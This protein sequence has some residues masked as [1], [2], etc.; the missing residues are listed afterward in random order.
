MSHQGHFLGYPAMQQAPPSSTGA[1]PSFHHPSFVPGGLPPSAY[2][3]F[4]MGP[5]DPQARRMSIDQMVNPEQKP[6][7]PAHPPNTA[8]MESLLALAGLERQQLA[9]K[10]SE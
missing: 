4:P 8:G 1:A 3:I 6:L 5:A 2:P 7:Q 9:F 10:H